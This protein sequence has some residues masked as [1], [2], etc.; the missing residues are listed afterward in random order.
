MELPFCAKQKFVAKRNAEAD[1]VVETHLF[2]F[3]STGVYKKLIK[4]FIFFVAFGANILPGDIGRQ[5]GIEI[6]M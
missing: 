3:L 6:K 1:P 5:V 2:L 4:V